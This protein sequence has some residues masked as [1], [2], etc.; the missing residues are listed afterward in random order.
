MSLLAAK[1]IWGL[2]CVAWYIIRYP[3]QRRARRT[4]VVERRDRV[5]D[6]VLMALSF[7][8]LGLIPLTYVLTGQ[9]KFAGY[10][11]RPLQAWLGVAVLIGRDG[12]CSTA[13]IAI[14]AAPGR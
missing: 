5:R 4:P 11:F 9:P 8:G 1:I 6:T 12:R 14:S 2:G 13:R 3:H 7:T 10:P